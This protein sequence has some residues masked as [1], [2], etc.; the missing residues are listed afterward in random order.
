MTL[1]FSH[2]SGY[3]QVIIMEQV[4]DVLPV[5]PFGHRGSFSVVYE[6]RGPEVYTDLFNASELRLC[7]LESRSA[8]QGESGRP[9]RSL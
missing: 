6:L 1:R 2:K 4:D 7:S 3:F 8:L 5:A 9:G